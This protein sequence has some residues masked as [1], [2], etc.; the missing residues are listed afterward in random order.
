MMTKKN[1][2]G[3]PVSTPSRPH[4][5][6]PAAALLLLAAVLLLGSSCKRRPLS[7]LDNNVTVNIEIEKDIVN[8]V[9]GEDPE[10]MRV[11]F[12]DSEDGTF[13]TQ[14]FLPAYGGSVSVPP[15][16]TYHIL[17]YNFDTESVAVGDEYLW[18]GIHATT[19]EV[20]EEARS[21]L[22]SRA[23]KYDDELIVYAPDH[24][25][26]GRTTD[27]YIPARSVDAPPVVIDLYARTIV[28]TWI[29]HI[30]RIQGMEYVSRVAGVISG[31]ALSNTLASD[32]ESR[33]EA[34]VFIESMH[35]DIGGKVDIT[36]NTFGRNPDYH[37][38]Q[39]LSLVVTDL[40]GDA[41]IFNFDVSDQFIDNPEQVIYINTDKIIIDEPD[42]S[43]DSG[44]G[45]NPDV[46]E[47][48]DVEIDIEI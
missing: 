39:V 16:E 17:T 36:F 15:G 37:N 18:D 14:A 3:N 41:H 29:V 35:Y 21:R 32:E 30:D 46:D 23:T 5:A 25:F 38:E 34:S 11:M 43:D 19:N 27:F 2:S 26:V 12:F 7:Q 13:A 45:V 48:E 22:R 20:S 24:H 40:G 10:M 8:Y 4:L 28:E 1:I 42:S 9:Y 44:G 33:E 31:L 47:W 6:M